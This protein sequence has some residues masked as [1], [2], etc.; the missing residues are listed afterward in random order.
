M[1][2]KTSRTRFLYGTSG[3]CVDLAP[4]LDGPFVRAG[5]VTTARRKRISGTDI[6][7]RSAKGVACGF[8]A[9][10]TIDPYTDPGEFL[11][12]NREGILFIAR[13]DATYVEAFPV[14]LT[15]RPIT[16]PASGIVT[17][18][19]AFTQTLGSAVGGALVTSGTLTVASG[20]V[21]YVAHPDNDLVAVTADTALTA[22]QLGVAGTPIS[23]EGV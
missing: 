5:R 7:G 17:L 15:S 20:S 1:S 8:S 4:V 22:G 23:A 3:G 12:A 9:T 19:C 11:T 13:A 2:Y 14:A 18:A 10:C 16:L 21:G 6:V